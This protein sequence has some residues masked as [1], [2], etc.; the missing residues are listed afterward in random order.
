MASVDGIVTALQ[1]A[2]DELNNSISVTAGAE[3]QTEDLGAQMSAAGIQDKAA[4][5]ANV[6]SAVERART[7]LMGG[8]DLLDEAINLARASGG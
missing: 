4:E 6:K 1:T 3:S 7:H 2:I 8:S 5:L